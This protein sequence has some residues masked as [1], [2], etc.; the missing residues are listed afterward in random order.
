[1]R[2]RGEDTAEAVRTWFGDEIK[3]SS[4]GFSDIGKFFFGVSS[5]S[6]GVILTLAKIGD[7]L[8]LSAPFFGSLILYLAS[9]IASI[10]LV[11]PRVW[12]LGGD[13]NLYD[14][15]KAT[16]RYGTNVIWIWLAFWVLA[17]C[18]AI[19]GLYLHQSSFMAT[20]F[21]HLHF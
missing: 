11:R 2:P 6:V 3:N 1:M 17:T 21:S 16:V 20:S 9:I 4:A 18:S 8:D 19:F 10:Q 14:E 13:T 15:Y 5:A 7:R 12:K